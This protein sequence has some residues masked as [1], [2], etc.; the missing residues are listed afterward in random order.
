MVAGKDI[1]SAVRTIATKTLRRG[2]AAL[3]NGAKAPPRGEAAQADEALHLDFYRSY[4]PDLASKSDDELRQHYRNFGRAEGRFASET[5]ALL[6]LHRDPRLP[7]DFSVESYLRLNPDV[8]RATRWPSEAIAHF[9]EKGRTEGRAY[10]REGLSEPLPPVTTY[11]PAIL[12]K[13]PAALQSE[14]SRQFFKRRAEDIALL[15][16]DFNLASYLALHQ[17][18]CKSIQHPHEGLAHYLD[19]GRPEN[20]SYAPMRVSRPFVMEVY[21]VDAGLSM[22]AALVLS[23]IRFKHGFSAEHLVYLSEEELFHGHG[24]VNPVCLELFNHEYYALAAGDAVDLSARRSECLFHFCKV[25]QQQGLNVSDRARFDPDFYRKEYFSDWSDEA[26]PGS[27]EARLRRLELFRDWLGSPAESNRLPN[28]RAW[29]QKT[30]EFSIPD[31]VVRQLTAYRNLVPDLRGA[32]LTEAARH[33][34]ACGTP[35]IRLIEIADV[36]VAEFFESIANA[37]SLE[38]EFEKADIVYHYLQ[39]RMPGYGPADHHRADHAFRRGDYYTSAQIR[40]RICAAGKGTRWAYR[41]LGESLSRLG[42]HAEAAQVLSRGVQL[43]PD[44]VDMRDKLRQ[45]QRTSF[46]S[47]WGRSAHRALAL[48]YAE[49]QNELRA[50]LASSTPV[51]VNPREQRTI[52]RVAILGGYDLPQCRYY[53]IDQKLE[54][55]GEAGFAVSAYNYATELDMFLGDLLKTDLVIFYRLPAFPNVIE[56]I[57]RTRQLGLPTIYDVDDLVFSAQHFPPSLASYAQQISAFEHAAIACGVPLF[58]HAMTLCEY[59][60]A[61]TR[62]LAHHVEQRVGTGIAFV[63][64]N[65][66]G[67]IRFDRAERSTAADRPVTVFYGSGTKAHKQ[68]FREIIEPAIAKLAKKFGKRVRFLLMGHIVLSDSLLPY[69]ERIRVLEPVKA[70]EDYWEFLAEADINLS[71]LSDSVFDG[72]KSE[73]K[74]L[75][76]AV[77]GIPSVVS[78][79]ATHED[80]IE[81]GRTG[82]L[83]DTSDDFYRAIERLVADAALRTAI[84]T[85]ARER[86]LER[87]SCEAQAETF[88]AIVGS[89]EARMP[90]IRKRLLV[91]N[92]FYPPQAIGGATR[93]VHDNV[94][95]LKEALGDDW[96]IDVICTLEGGPKPYAIDWYVEDG[97]RVFAITAADRPDIDHILEDRQMAAAFATCFDIIRPDLV[98]FHCIQRLTT[99]IVDVTIEKRVPYLITMHDGWWISPLQFLIDEHDDVQL[100]DLD[101]VVPDGAGG[102]LL[103]PRARRLRRYLRSA[104][105]ITT[106]SEGFAEVC[107]S[108]GLRDVRVVENGVSRIPKPLRTP[109]SEGRVRL[110]HIGGLSRHKGYHH[111]TNIFQTQDFANL[112]LLVVDHSLPSDMR[113]EEIWGNTP[114]VIQGKTPQRRV[115]EMYGQIDVL[116][117]PSVWPESYGLVTREALAAGCWVV[118]SD[119][120][121]IGGCVTPGE[122]GFIVDVSS[123]RGLLDALRAIDADPQRYRTSPAAAP[124]IRP[125]S[126]QAAELAAIYRGLVG[127]GG[128][129]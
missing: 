116:L 63:Y 48:D 53:R 29:F 50:A 115:D 56:A 9:L 117:A 118:A 3:R 123:P 75:E 10:Q 74:W 88:K 93:V 52:R 23:E 72:C 14:E 49:V 71:V 19:H 70:L 37:F 114:V 94:R 41:M 107:R 46:E 121:A 83:C 32:S 28:L 6:R 103:P 25:G 17:D 35:D 104:K 122:N 42:D 59:G 51:L 64:P 12:R 44:D 84:G 101:H 15:P 113:R 111:V 109:R 31:A 91:V 67:K 65:A 38:E 4:Y 97:I 95:D 1:G 43:Y 86:A 81:D 124:S 99:S 98:H 26:A 129:T 22:P 105:L 77:M 30:Y 39:Q 108:A 47:L 34:V 55:L 66:L 11:D 125:A 78:R 90:K 18:V 16:S 127:E 76:A 60:M 68:D 61:S 36:S 45:T 8:K 21:G 33:L 120:G 80:V 100:Y 20:R 54:Q 110:A 79:T 119:R 27:E 96:Q 69:K 85:A 57:A 112:E 7:S 5:Q 89:I 73:I 58:E 2:R 87:Y 40:A 106:V 62:A 24:I 102:A 82:L 126:D 128:A 13:Y 92:V